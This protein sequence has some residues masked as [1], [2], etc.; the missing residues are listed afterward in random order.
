[1]GARVILYLKCLVLLEEQQ[2]RAACCCCYRMDA[3]SQ[4][5]ERLWPCPSRN[6]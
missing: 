4:A 1:M 3:G 6:L 2:E 5:G